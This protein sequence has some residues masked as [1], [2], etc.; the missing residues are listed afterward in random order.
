MEVSKNGLVVIDFYA[1]WCGPCKEVEPVFAKFPKSYPSVTFAKIDVDEFPEA[2]DRFTING[3]PTFLF[4]K[5]GKPVVTVMGANMTT[6][7]NKIKQHILK[8]A[9]KSC[10]SNKCR[11]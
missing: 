5:G 1:T 6:L 2:A 10:V 4:I 9:A 3:M 7:E 8:E 11:K